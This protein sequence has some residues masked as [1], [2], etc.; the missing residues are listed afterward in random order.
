MFL[1]LGARNFPSSGLCGCYRFF[2]GY[3]VKFSKV[4]CVLVWVEGEGKFR[5]RMKR[6][7]RLCLVL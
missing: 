5:I 6:F 1:F 7:I 4:L 3:M 2:V